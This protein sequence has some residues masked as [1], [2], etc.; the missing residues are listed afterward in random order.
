MR[1]GISDDSPAYIDEVQPSVCALTAQARSTLTESTSVPVLRSTAMTRGRRR[2]RRKPLPAALAD[3]QLLLGG[4]RGT[5]DSGSVTFR[6][7]W[8]YIDC[9]ATAGKAMKRSSVP[10]LYHSDLA[11]PFAS[12]RLPQARPR[13]GSRRAMPRGPP[14]PAAKRSVTHRFLR[15][16]FCQEGSCALTKQRRV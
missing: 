5:P 11:D 12:F 6:L 8:H 3:E 9:G 13:R 7:R 2:R 14:H 1:W 16:A 10:N 4:P 15:R